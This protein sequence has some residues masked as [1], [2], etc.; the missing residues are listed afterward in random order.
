LELRIKVGILLKRK[1]TSKEKTVLFS[2]FS[3]EGKQKYGKGEKES[4]KERKNEE[5]GDKKILF[6][7]LAGEVLKRKKGAKP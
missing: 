6:H 4:K 2:R 5:T 1:E 7:F 3:Q